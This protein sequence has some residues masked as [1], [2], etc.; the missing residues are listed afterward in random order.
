MSILFVI[1]IAFRSTPK[2]MVR[3]RVHIIDS[4]IASGIFSFTFIIF[5]TPYVFHK[6]GDPQIYFLSTALLNYA[7]KK[8]PLHLL[9][10]GCYFAAFNTARAVILCFK[11]R[12]DAVIYGRF[13]DQYLRW[14]K[15][16]VY[17]LIIFPFI[18]TIFIVPNATHSTGFRAVVKSITLSTSNLE[19]EVEP[20]VL[21]LNLW[22]KILQIAAFL[23]CGI[24][25]TFYI[26]VTYVLLYLNRVVAKQQSKKILSTQR[27]AFTMLLIQRNGTLKWTGGS[28]FDYQKVPCFD[29]NQD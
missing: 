3:Y 27:T 19:I 14:D 23:P 1:F 8:I 9:L 11:Y 22:L 25:T 13:R 12:F 6:N 15:Y 17:P 4:L 24:L 21:D 16:L 7:I 10:I 18:A 28:A 29:T 20:L 5:Y 26:C 2:K